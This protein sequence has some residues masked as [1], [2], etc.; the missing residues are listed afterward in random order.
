LGGNLENLERKH[1]GSLFLRSLQGR[2]GSGVARIAVVV[3]GAPT[4]E[5]RVTVSL[6][7]S[8]DPPNRRAQLTYVV[9]DVF[10]IWYSE[11]AAHL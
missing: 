10:K 2:V 1:R 9:T 7:R 5:I 6:D 11:S 8:L 4:T 3:H